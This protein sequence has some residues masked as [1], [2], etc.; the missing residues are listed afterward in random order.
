MEERISVKLF[1]DVGMGE[2]FM[3]RLVHLHD[4]ILSGVYGLDNKKEIKNSIMRVIF[5]GLEPAFRSLREIRKEWADDKVPE[6]RKRQH[7]E[8][9]YLYLTIA[10]KDRFQQT[11]K[12]FGYDIGFIFQKDSAFEKEAEKFIKLYPKIGNDLVQVAKYHRANW[13]SK[14]ISVRNDVIDHAGEKDRER[15]KELEKGLTLQ[16]AESL[17]DNCW[18]AIEDAILLFVLDRY[19]KKYGHQLLELEAYRTDKNHLKRFGW[20]LIPGHPANRNVTP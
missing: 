3:A 4:R 10:F 8:N 15:I 1:S 18:R 20:F 14:I 6:K 12:E 13:L 17:F 7:I 2:V 9:V 16:Y 19:D 5:D 11:A